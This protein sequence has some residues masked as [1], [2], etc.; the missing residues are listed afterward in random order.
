[1]EKIK[2]IFKKETK[3]MYPILT[4]EQKNRALEMLKLMQ[5][6]GEFRYKSREEQTEKP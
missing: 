4:P 2:L 6:N 1:M 3:R 5:D